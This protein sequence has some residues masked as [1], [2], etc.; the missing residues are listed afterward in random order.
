MSKLVEDAR[1]LLNATGNSVEEKVVAARNR[2]VA[3]LD[4][5]KKNCDQMREKAVESANAASQI[6]RDH[7]CATISV[8]FSVGALFGG[9]LV[10][11]K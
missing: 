2:L 3:T 9:F 11:H 1:N 4:S 10:H 5:G 6:A 7:L 8:A